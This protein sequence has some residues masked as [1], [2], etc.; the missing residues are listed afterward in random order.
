MTREIKSVMVHKAIYLCSCTKE[1]LDRLDI[2]KTCPV[3]FSDCMVSRVD[4]FQA[5][6]VVNNGMIEYPESDIYY[7]DLG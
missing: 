5:E 3:C 1:Y 2:P 7:K 4:T 6:R